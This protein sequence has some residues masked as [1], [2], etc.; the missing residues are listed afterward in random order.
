MADG[1]LEVVVAAPERTPI[2]VRATE[3]T[4]PGEAGVFSVLPGHTPLLSK[5][6][7]GVM[8]VYTQDKQK[9][10]FALHGGFAEVSRDTVTILAGAMERH[11]RIDVKR[12][13][14]ARARA[15]ELLKRSSS[16]LDV[17][18]AEAA[19]ARALARLQAASKEHF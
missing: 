9:L 8:L 18:R 5:L 12:A 16:D 14:A 4:I 7:H 11:D 19:L 1:L 6:T 13:Q 15:L 2:Q 10:F 17:A 3:V